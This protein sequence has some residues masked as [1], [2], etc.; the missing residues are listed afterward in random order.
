MLRDYD[1][2]VEDLSRN[3]EDRKSVLLG[4]VPIGKYME[5]KRNPLK[6]HLVTWEKNLADNIVS[7]R[8]LRERHLEKPVNWDYLEGQLD[9]TTQTFYSLK[10]VLRREI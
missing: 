1:K 8:K 10:E 9:A 4:D 5:P 6:E 3:D 2:T 7:M